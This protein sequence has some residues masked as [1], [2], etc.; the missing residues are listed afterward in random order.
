M[1]AFRYAFVAKTQPRESSLFCESVDGDTRFL[2]DE[3]RFR[4]GGSVDNCPEYFSKSKK[5]IYSNAAEGCERFADWVREV[6]L[7]I[8]QI[9][10]SAPTR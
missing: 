7:V 2:F 3:L 4:M 10:K 1:F 9:K 5:M 6:V 8:D